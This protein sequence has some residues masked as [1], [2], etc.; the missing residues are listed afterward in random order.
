MKI[1]EITQGTIGQ[2]EQK[3]KATETVPTEFDRLLIEEAG[4]IMAETAQVQ[5]E[6]GTELGALSS[7]VPFQLHPMLN[8]FSDEYQQ[9][10]LAV[11]G[12]LQRMERLQLALQD[13]TGTLRSVGAAVDDLRAGAEELQ[14]SVASLPE[15]HQ[16][17]QMA[18]E[19]AVLAHVESVKY[20]RGDYL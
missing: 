17:R 4:K 3:T 1:S 10:E 11:E 13:P 6:P 2:Q 20:R 18:D 12:A 14:Q 8:D 9:A 7:V 16:L 19:L 15:N 5:A